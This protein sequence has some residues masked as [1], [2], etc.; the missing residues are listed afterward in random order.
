MPITFP[1]ELAMGI[2]LA[3]I[4][5][6]A[7]AVAS[8]ILIRVLPKPARLAFTVAIAIAI[9]QP[10]T[11]LPDVFGL[12]GQAVANAAV[13]F[14]LAFA[15]G[16]PFYAFDVAGSITELGAGLSAAQ[17]LDP[18]G[19]H[20]SGLLSTMF[21]MTALAILMVLGGDRLIV[22]GIALSVKAV[23][24]QG[25]I[26]VHGAGIA[27]LL[28]D[29]VGSLLLAGVELAAPVIAALF[30][31]DLALAAAARLAPQTNAFMLGLPMKL[32]VTLALLS[33][34]V[35][36]FPGMVQQTMQAMTQGMTDVLRAF[37]S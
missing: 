32:L 3:L 37:H 4:R 18:G 19:D 20:T 21:S 16:L 14:V 33:A 7:F 10:V 29:T 28:V 30:L 1:A 2:V 23:P 13:G 34:V 12:A 25:G 35:T 6:G 22:Q 8:P 27:K 24:F 9:A 31:T 36:I 11:S 15:S 5:V 17:I 26:A